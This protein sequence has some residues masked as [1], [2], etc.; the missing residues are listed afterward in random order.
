MDTKTAIA[1]IDNTIEFNGLEFGSLRQLAEV[2]NFLLTS[3]SDARAVEEELDRLKEENSRLSE[4]LESHAWEISP[5]MAQAK[6]DELTADLA[7][8]RATNADLYAEFKR[9]NDGLS[10]E[11]DRLK[12]ELR[13]L[14]IISASSDKQGFNWFDRATKAEVELAAAREEIAAL[15]A[16]LHAHGYTD[17]DIKALAHQEGVTL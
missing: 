12:A 5:A 15:K 1:Y 9:Q 10:E 2:K 4:E 16:R 8:A 17:K 14:K 3:H 7:A 6:I 13:E 11:R